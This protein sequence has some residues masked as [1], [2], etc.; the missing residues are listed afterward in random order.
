MC[1][2]L[3]MHELIKYQ[4][5]ANSYVIVISHYEQLLDLKSAVTNLLY[6]GY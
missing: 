2:S 6:C 3:S 5:Y 4:Q 1:T